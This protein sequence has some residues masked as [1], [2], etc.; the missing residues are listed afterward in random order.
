MILIIV[1]LISSS[2]SYLYAD[3]LESP[4][5]KIVDATT[6][7]G[8]E[9]STSTGYNLLNTI[10]SFSG[11]PRVYS[12][13]Y[14]GGLGAIEI[15]L[16]NVPQISCFETTSNGS[17]NCTTGPS[18][19]NTNGMTTVCGPA[20]C[21]DRAR[22][23]I[24]TQNNP[25]DTLYGVQIS[26]DNFASDI[27]YIDGVTFKPKT[28]NQRTIND[29][30][31]KAAWETNA[32]N[33]TGLIAGTEYDLRIVGLHG[34]FTESEPGPIA[35]A[36]TASTYMT[37]DLDID[38]T[39]GISAETAPPYI[40]DFSTSRKLI[41]TGPPQTAAD[42]IWMDLST[43]ALGGFALVQKG[44]SGG[45]HSTSQSYTIPSDNFDLDGQ[46]E[47]FG[48]QTYY[49][50]QER[51]TSSGNGDLG[52]VDTVAEYDGSGNVVGKVGQLF[53]KVFESSK[54]VL[55]GRAGMQLKARASGTTPVSSDYTEDITFIMV[56]R[57]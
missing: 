53:I 16:A 29:Y 1:I 48:L 57:Y 30:L 10:G 32:I 4:N 6:N 18:Y 2:L 37:F 12:T 31:T 27:R 38:N 35:T 8:G 43:N 20:G 22:F 36:T 46:S 41:Q 9:T 14:R 56:P 50:A 26:Q 3:N 47:G 19:L 34:D 39:S 44:S 28:S 23:E 52:T 5:Y 45:L 33:I 51:N 21:Y 11:D 24:D 7:G 49:T 42:L 15:F 25:A 54:P 40:V 55:N 17:S 13:N